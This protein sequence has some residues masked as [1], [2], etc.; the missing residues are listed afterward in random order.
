MVMQAKKERGTRNKARSQVTR[1]A[2]LK[3]AKELFSEKGMDLTTID[4]ITERANVG[5]GTFYYYFTDKNG[6]IQELVRDILNGLC[7]D[8]DQKCRDVND[9]EDLMDRLIQTH[10]EFFDKRWE[11]FVLYFQVTA[12][13]TLQEG[14]D[15]IDKS[16]MN[17]LDYLA[18]LL[19]AQIHHH[20]KHEALTRLACAVA[21]FVSG[22]YSFAVIASE[23]YQDTLSPARKALAAALTR[24]IGVSVQKVET[25]V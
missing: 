6:I 4:N 13:L 17:Y 24:F 21:G 16:M 12:D 9:L 18:G 3:A 8:V 11:D 10:L 7:H 25:T 22:Y 23:D 1:K 19:D 14:Y 20:L 5:K 15:G 2:L